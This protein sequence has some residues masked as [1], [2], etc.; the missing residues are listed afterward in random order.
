MAHLLMSITPA[1]MHRRPMCACARMCTN[2]RARARRNCAPWIPRLAES[3][4]SLPSEYRNLG[5]GEG[6]SVKRSDFSFSRSTVAG[7]AS[8]SV[9]ANSRRE[10]REASPRQRSALFETPRARSS[11][12]LKD[13]RYPR[14]GYISVQID[15]EREN[16]TGKFVSELCQ[17]AMEES[18]AARRRGLIESPFGL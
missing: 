17:T 12:T 14:V 3:P 1:G 8:R 15:G 10:K 18:H 2:M 5:K 4:C 6:S 13:Y 11:S 16:S 9:E 7:E